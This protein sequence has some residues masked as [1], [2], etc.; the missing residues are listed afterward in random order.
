MTW[1]GGPSPAPPENGEGIHSH[2]CVLAVSISPLWPLQSPHFPYLTPHPEP[3]PVLPIAGP[4][5]SP[6]HSPLSTLFPFPFIPP[7]ASPS[8]SRLQAYFD[9]PASSILWPVRY[10]VRRHIS[11]TFAHSSGTPN[12]PTGIFLT[13]PGV[14]LTKSSEGIM[15]VSPIIWRG[16]DVSKSLLS[17]TLLRKSFRLSHRV[18]GRGC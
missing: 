9:P 14:P 6:Y 8:H 15:P 11:T 4:P 2:I 12:L 16:D 17:L 18:M 10:P 5:P 3:L 1:C 7:A 13:S